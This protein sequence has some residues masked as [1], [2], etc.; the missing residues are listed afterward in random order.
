MICMK[1][2]FAVAAHPYCI[3]FYSHHG[4]EIEELI[5]NSFKANVTLKAAD[6]F[7]RVM[8]SRISRLTS[9]LLG[10]PSSVIPNTSHTSF[11]SAQKIR[12]SF[13]CYSSQASVQRINSV[14]IFFFS[15]WIVPLISVS[16]N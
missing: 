1:H 13:S 10:V 12:A 2:S 6:S 4:L 16:L 3:L 5:I 11:S 9:F 15:G 7:K 8:K 14:I